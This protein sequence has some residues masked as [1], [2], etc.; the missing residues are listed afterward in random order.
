[1][2][3]AGQ[4]SDLLQRRAR[5]RLLGVDPD[6]CFAD[7][8]VARP[9]A[10]L[11]ARAAR[12]GVTGPRS[13]A[14]LK[15][16]ATAPSDARSDLARRSAATVTCRI[17]PL[18]GGA[19]MLTLRSAG[20]R[21]LRHRR[22]AGPADRGCRLATAR[23]SC[24]PCMSATTAFHHLRQSR[25]RP[26]R[27]ARRLGAGL[28]PGDAL[29]LTGDI[30]AGKTHFARCADPVACWPAPEDV[31]SPTLRWFRP[32]PAGRGRSGMPIFTG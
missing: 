7:M 24:A 15:H 10:R 29:L 21:P 23:V 8:T 9:V 18:P 11:A 27:I 20:A 4:C 26:A 30:G 1:M 14:E 13:S 19:R 3:G 2:I 31:P 22:T 28:R 32:M 5:S 6:I 25:T 17:E 16:A 12:P